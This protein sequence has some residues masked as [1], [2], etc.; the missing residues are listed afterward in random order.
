M[1]LILAGVIVWLIICALRSPHAAH[2]AEI[3]ELRA[4]IETLEERAETDASIQAQLSAITGTMF[5]HTRNA[6]DYENY[7]RQHGNHSR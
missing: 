2:E 6:Q 1:E 5:T 7:L 3:S 4:R